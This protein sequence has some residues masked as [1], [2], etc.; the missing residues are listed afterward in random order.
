V[1]V[2]SVELPA[3]RRDTR[4][5]KWKA[6]H[7][8]LEWRVYYF[9]HDDGAS[10]C[11]SPASG[12]FRSAVKE[13][14]SPLSRSLCAK[15]L[16][17]L[18]L[19]LVLPFKRDCNRLDCSVRR[20]LVLT[21]LNATI[22]LRQISHIQS[23]G[24]SARLPSTRLTSILEKNVTA[25]ARRPGELPMT[26]NNLQKPHLQRKIYS[27]PLFLSNPEGREGNSFAA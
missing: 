8:V 16:H 17:G 13:L 3:R 9:F 25:S 15:W 1:T 12:L 6:F 2:Q 20:Y 7:I 26:I 19:K 10:I 22:L 11:I 4:I 5:Q 14:R 27:L 21:P 23:L 18:L 24:Y